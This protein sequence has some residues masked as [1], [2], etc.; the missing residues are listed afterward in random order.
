M[1]QFPICSNINT[2]GHMLKMA[3][4][5]LSWSIC[6][7]YPY[8]KDGEDVCEDSIEIFSVFYK[9]HKSQNCQT[10]RAYL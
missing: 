4:I 9:I 2:Y 7:F 1:A 8:E 6:L 10:K 5:I 3:K